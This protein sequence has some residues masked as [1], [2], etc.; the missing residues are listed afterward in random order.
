MRRLASAKLY[1]PRAGTGT[2]ARSA[3]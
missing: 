1:R 3:L 2:D